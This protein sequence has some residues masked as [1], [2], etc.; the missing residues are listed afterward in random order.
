[1]HIH[2]PN[3]FSHL[4][5]ETELRT[6]HRKAEAAATRDHTP[7]AVL[8]SLAMSWFSSPSSESDDRREL[9]ISAGLVL[10]FG[11]QHHRVHWGHRFLTPT[12][13]IC[14]RYRDKRPEDFALD[15]VDSEPKSWKSVFLVEYCVACSVCRVCPI[16]FCRVDPRYS[17]RHAE[18]KLQAGGGLQADGY[19]F[20]SCKIKPI[21]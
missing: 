13:G 19:A 9:S 20:T 5:Q 14:R 6:E 11:S 2:L 16:G 3:G 12:F 18:P 15:P 7:K 4:S 21:R 8:T 17:D 10:G 1:M